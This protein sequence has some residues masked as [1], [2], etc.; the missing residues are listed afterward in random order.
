M[1]NCVGGEQ[2]S[3]PYTGP[4]GSRAKYST[5]VYVHKSRACAQDRSPDVDS[6]APPWTCARLA[7]GRNN[8]NRGRAAARSLLSAFCAQLSLSLCLVTRPHRLLGDGP[9]QLPNAPRAL[10]L[11]SCST[12]AS[13]HIPD[14]LSCSRLLP[15]SLLLSL[16]RSLDN[17]R[18]PSSNPVLRSAA[19]PFVDPAAR[20]P[21]PPWHSRKLKFP[22]PTPGHRI[23]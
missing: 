2:A 18:I 1:N 11:T 17:T 22:P 5:V 21:R 13:P 8:K 15:A 4:Q 9:C 10:S 6:S 7:Q 12:E 16:A 19:Q 23:V 14:A 20:C 3:P